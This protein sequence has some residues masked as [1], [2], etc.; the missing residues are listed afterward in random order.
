M[1]RAALILIGYIEAAAQFKV[2]HRSPPQHFSAIYL[3]LKEAT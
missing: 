2:F 3:S 1:A